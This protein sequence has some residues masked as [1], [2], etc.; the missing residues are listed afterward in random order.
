MAKI[1]T[2]N[3]GVWSAVGFT[4]GDGG[5]ELGESGDYGSSEAE[6]EERDG[7]GHCGEG[8]RVTKEED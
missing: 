1:L 6:E 5:F 4:V 8:E 7:G 3:S 2:S